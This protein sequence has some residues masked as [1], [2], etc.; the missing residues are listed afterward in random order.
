MPT[1]P[2]PS[3]TAAAYMATVT[4]FDSHTIGRVL[5]AALVA[6]LDGLTVPVALDGTDGRSP[7]AQAEVAIQD[8]VSH[9]VGRLAVAKLERDR[10][11]GTLHMRADAGGFAPVAAITLAPA[12]TEVAA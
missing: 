1:T 11:F 5:P 9:I 6:A 4:A 10:G 2:A 7:C 3:P 12:L 8:A